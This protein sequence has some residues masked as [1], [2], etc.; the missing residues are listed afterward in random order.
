MASNQV[1]VRKRILF[2]RQQ[3]PNLSVRDLAKKLKL[4]KSTVFSVCKSFDQ[5]LTVERKV[6]SGTNRKVSSRNMDRKVV[7]IIEKSPSL[8]VRN[9]ACKVRKIKSYVQRVKQGL[10]TEDVQSEKGA[11]PR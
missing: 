1:E 9:V 7:A 2:E 6:G 3:N 10:N 4:P 5:R 11:Q 8:S